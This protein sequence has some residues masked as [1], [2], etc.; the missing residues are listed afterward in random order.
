MK[1]SKP[2]LIS[3]VTA[4]LLVAAC[5]V[6][7]PSDSK[8]G[9]DVSG[10][11]YT[12]Q[13]ITYIVTDPTDPSSGGAEP[14]DPFGAGG[15]MCCFRLPK[16]WQAGI[17]VRVEILDTNRQPV[18]EELLELPPYVDGK[19]GRIW[20]VYYPDGSVGVLSSEYGPPH[21]KWPGKVKGWPVP[22]VEYRRKLWEQQLELRK[23]SLHVA[24][25]LIKE[26][27][28]RPDVSLRESWDFKKQYS[29]KEIERF[30]G[31]DDPAF[32]SFLQESY[33]RSL[34]RAQQRIDEWITKKP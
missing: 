22:T 9:V 6:P 14:V 10:V 4:I 31:P 21:E 28:E 3:A 34:S 13:P 19:P 24:Q 5:A 17:K 1:T 15:A 7:R 12:D 32:K 29:W 30:S 2:T 11:N 33:A 25:Q 23:D 26:L 8:V 20:A 16:T 18:K 27:K